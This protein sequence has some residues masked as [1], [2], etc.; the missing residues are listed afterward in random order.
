MWLV[1][2]QGC[3]MIVHLPYY[4]V[5]RV[6]PREPVISIITGHKLVKVIVARAS[7]YTC[8]FTREI[9]MRLDLKRECIHTRTLSSF[10]QDVIIPKIHTSSILD[11][12]RV[13]QEIYIHSLLIF[14]LITNSL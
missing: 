14:P 3:I 6:K 4:I 1:F 11:H 2:S 10:V 13:C 8:K 7:I 5:S 12:Q 9:Y